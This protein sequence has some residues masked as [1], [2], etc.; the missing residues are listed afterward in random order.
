MF[1]QNI[2]N[3][4]LINEHNIHTQTATG[5]WLD[6]MSE[7]LDALLNISK[8]TCVSMSM[9]VLLFLWTRVL[10]L[11]SPK[12]N[13]QQHAQDYSKNSVDALCKPCPWAR[14]NN[15]DYQ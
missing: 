6:W 3:I 11:L 9:R 4:S 10:L 15:A 14:I 2:Q 5:L 12:P 8:H 13:L 7:S 1:N